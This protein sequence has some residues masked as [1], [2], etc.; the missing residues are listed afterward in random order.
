MRPRLA[1][2]AFTLAVVGFGASRASLIVYNAPTFC[3]ESGCDIVRA[4]A[5]AHPLGIPMPLFGLAF[6][7]AMNGLS[8]V[9]R[10]TA[11]KLLALGGVFWA[12][13]LFVLLVFV[14]GVWC[15]FCLF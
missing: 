14:F 2:A 11:R 9:S 1:L 6:F 10:P 15:L 12:F 7:A 5:W 13:V 4:S 3:A 8:F